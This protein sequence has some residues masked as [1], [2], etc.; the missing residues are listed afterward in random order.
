MASPDMVVSIKR[1]SHPVLGGLSLVAIVRSCVAL[2]KSCP[3][4][5]APA[6]SP[7]PVADKPIAAPPVAA[8]PVSAPV[9]APVVAPPV[10]ADAKPAE[11]VPPVVAPAVPESK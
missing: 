2:A 7:A 6:A 3:P 5:P 11:V 9:I 10:A 8:V 1:H 4:V